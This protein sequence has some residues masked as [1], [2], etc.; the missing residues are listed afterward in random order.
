MENTK[1]EN[2]QTKDGGNDTKDFVYYEDSTEKIFPIDYSIRE[3]SK[4]RKGGPRAVR[5]RLLSAPIL[6][7]ILLQLLDGNKRET[8]APPI[9]LEAKLFLE[10]FYNLAE[11]EKSVYGSLD[12]IDD[13]MINIFF[14]KLSRELYHAVIEPEEFNGQDS[15]A[16]CRHIL[17]NNTAFQQSIFETLWEEKINQRYSQLQIMSKTMSFENKIQ[18]L[19]IYLLA[20]DDTILKL[21]NLPQL[22]SKPDEDGKEALQDILQSLL[23]YRTQT[24]N[25]ENRYHE[26]SNIAVDG[27]MSLAEAFI[28]LKSPKWQDNQLMRKARQAYLVSLAGKEPQSPFELNYLEFH[29][30]LEFTSHPM[31]EQKLSSFIENHCKRYCQNIIDRFN[32]NDYFTIPDLFQTKES[33]NYIAQL[34]NNTVRQNMESA[35]SC[36]PDLVRLMDHYQSIR[37][38]YLQ[39]TAHQQIVLKNKLSGTPLE[40]KFDI[41]DLSINNTIPCYDSKPYYLKEALPF[42][43]FLQH[44]WN[45]LYK[46]E[47]QLCNLIL[48][49]DVSHRRLNSNTVE[50]VLWENSIRAAEFFDRNNLFS[51]SLDDFRNMFFAYDFIIENPHLLLSPC[52]LL[53]TIPPILMGIFL[54]ILY[55]VVIDCEQTLFPSLQYLIYVFRE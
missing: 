14:K 17:F 29:K 3:F 32:N 2:N 7:G 48:F 11:E 27:T 9:P 25:P 37:F 24:F 46:K 13:Q 5:N 19:V 6:N 15:N 43:Q 21:H 47:P 20:L 16:Y 40:D 10:K 52:M 55:K 22:E 41:Y 44:S 23:S 4:G 33:P 18:A 12:E 42:A 28:R 45:F 49:D 53:D 38:F 35:L 51:Y 8:N 54:Q 36:F 39:L 34:I 31:N 30:Y 50:N 1:K 26:I